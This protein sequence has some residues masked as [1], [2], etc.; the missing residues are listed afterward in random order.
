MAVMD[1]NMLSPLGIFFLVIFGIESIVSILGNGFII[2]VNC[3]SW[4][5]SQKILLCDFLLITLSLS[6]FL[7]QWITMSSQFVYLGYPETYIHSKKQQALT[8]CWAYLNTA[9][10]W[11]AT[12][13]NVFYCVKVTNFP[14]PLFAW[15]KLRIGALVPRCLGI[16]LLAFMICSIYPAM[17]AFEDE[18]CCNL[19]G[20]LPDDTRQSEAHDHNPFRFLDL[21]QLYS[22][23]ISFNI[24]LTA[25]SVLLLSL[26]RHTK[27][28]KKSGLSTKDLS[29]QAHLNV[30]KPLLLLLIFYVIHFAAM[31]IS[32]TR[33]F[34]YGKLEWLISDIFL[35][36]YPS[37]HSIILIFTNPKLRK[38]CTRVLSLRRSPS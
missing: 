23:A 34:K 36:S 16:S 6:R 11:C 21:L 13:L 8:I 3:C 29:T 38:V 10:L 14:H 33:F 15:L 30:M 24:C 35:S 12:W 4:L 25:S 20:N 9:S 31:I 17:R 2:V 7:W 28:L 19:T 22:A 32:L 1:R 5:Q 27:N 18:K 37:A 26:W